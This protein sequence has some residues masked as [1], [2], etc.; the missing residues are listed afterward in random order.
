[1]NIPVV[2]IEGGE[3]SGSI[4]ES[5]RHAITKLAN[6]HFPASKSAA[7]RIIKMGEREDTVFAVGSTSLDILNDTDLLT[8]EY[9]ED[10]QNLHGVG[11]RQGIRANEF[12]IVIQHPVTTEYEQNYRNVRET[13]KAVHEMALPTLWIWPNMDAGSD[14]VSKAI[15]DYREKLDPAHVYFFKSLPIEIYGIFLKQAACIVGNSSSGIREAAFLGT[16]CVN[17][18]TRQDGRDRGRNARDVGYCKNEIVQA[19]KQQITAGRCMPDYLY[20]DGNAAGKIVDILE[21][22]K[23]T[24][25]KQNSY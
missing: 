21:G 22:H 18:G 2:H 7:D 11:K 13:V 4:D 19:T 14:G 17:I 9:A 23:F 16:P 8:L 3:I 20:G 10:Y 15:R 5:I 12:L 6:L 1:M 24:K 25:Q